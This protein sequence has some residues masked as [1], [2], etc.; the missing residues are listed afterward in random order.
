[1]DPRGSIANKYE[2]QSLIGCFRPVGTKCSGD[3]RVA[4]D[5]NGVAEGIVGRGNWSNELLLLRPDAPAADKDVCRTLIEARRPV[6]VGR[7]NDNCVATQRNGGAEG[8]V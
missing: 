6:V 1:M 7:A 4:V 3:E 8:V 5:G 2:G